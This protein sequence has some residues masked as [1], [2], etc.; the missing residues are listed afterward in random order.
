METNQTGRNFCAIHLAACQQAEPTAATLCNKLAEVSERLDQQHTFVVGQF[1]QWK[2]GLKNRT[3]PDY[4]EPA[5]VRAVFPYPIFD[6]AETAAS[7]AYF[8]EPL[9]IVAGVFRE[10]DFLEFR[11]DGRRL[12][13]LTS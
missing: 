13:P 10:G 8:Q 1:V 5:I 7:S 11:L 3:F 12:E 4:G 6:P 9:S 2:P